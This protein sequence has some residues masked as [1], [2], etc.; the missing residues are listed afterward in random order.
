MCSSKGMAVLVHSGHDSLIDR[1][2]Y[3]H[4]M[5]LTYMYVHMYMYVYDN[6]I[7]VL[8]SIYTESGESRES[9]SVE[10]IHHVR[11]FQ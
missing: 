1:D 8:C 10:Y 9:E 3:M 11:T 7:Y 6:T 5:V 4:N 2:A